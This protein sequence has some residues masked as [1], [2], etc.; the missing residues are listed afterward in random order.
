MK[1]NLLLSLAIGLAVNASGAHAI[2][3]REAQNIINK[4]DCRTIRYLAD[5]PVSP[6]CSFQVQSVRSK[7]RYSGV[8]QVYSPGIFYNLNVTVD[9]VSGRVVAVRKGEFAGFSK[10]SEHLIDEAADQA[11]DHV[12]EKAFERKDDKNP[13]N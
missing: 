5:Y 6:L 2:D 3:E 10:L 9:I 8:A 11:V 7:G 13:N 1:L 12:I 4:T